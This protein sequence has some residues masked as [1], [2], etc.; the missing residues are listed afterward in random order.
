MKRRLYLGVC[1]GLVS[2][3][4]GCTSEESPEVVSETPAST[5]TD[6]SSGNPTTDEGDERQTSTSSTDTDTEAPT[7]Q[8][9]EATIG[10]VVKDDTLAMLV[11]G[12]SK[13]KKI[14]EFQEAEDGNTYVVIDLGIKNTT[15][16]EYI[17]F[18]GLL[19]TRLKDSEGYTYDQTFAATGRNLD[20][21]QIA[22]GEVSRGD[23]VFEIPEDAAGLLLQ[24][25]FQGF[26][27]FKFSR[28]EVDLTKEADSSGSLNQDLQVEVFEPEKTVKF[29]DTQVTMNGVETGT[30][31][32]SFA[33]AQEGNEFVIVD[34]TTTNNT[35]EELT[36]ST[37][38]QMLLKDDEGFNYP[39][40][41]TATSQLDRSYEQGSPLASGETRRGKVAYEVPTGTK[42][43]YWV[44]EFSIW[45]EGSKTFWQAR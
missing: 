37:L 42:P 25:D 39:L 31:L 20:G 1:G 40:S 13:T 44:F 26:S 7:T 14:G 27:L 22:P 6:G 8:V 16:S 45:V 9:A 43:L 32:G 29:A 34:I 15:S 24:F 33:E 4:A 2:G 30:K 17:S 28:V 3:I 18:S 35:D 23:V 21:G 38:L 36:I 10:Q 41:I 5:A 12:V 19:Q 11:T